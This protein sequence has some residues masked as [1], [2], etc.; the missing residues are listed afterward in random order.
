MAIQYGFSSCTDGYLFEVW[1][2][3]TNGVPVGITIGQVFYVVQADPIT[4]YS[5]CATCV[6]VVGFSDPVPIFTSGLTMVYYPTCNECLLD[7]DN[8][9]T[10]ETPTPTPTATQTPKPTLSS[11]AT[12]TPTRTLTPT[13]TRTLTPTPTITS[14]SRPI[15]DP[16]YIAT[17][18]A[19][20]VILFDPETFTFL[21]SPN[22]WFTSLGQNITKNNVKLWSINTANSLLEYNITVYPPTSTIVTLDPTIILLQICSSPTTNQLFIANG[23]GSKNEIQ[24]VSLTTGAILSTVGTLPSGYEFPYVNTYFGLYYDPVENVFYL[25]VVQTGQPYVDAIFVKY[26]PISQTFLAQSPPPG[27]DQI[28]NGLFVHNNTLYVTTYPTAMGGD[29]SI[30]SIV[31]NSGSFTFTQVLDIISELGSPTKTIFS[32]WINTRCTERSF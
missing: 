1:S 28:I 10:I 20:N 4:P 3:G 6:N 24:T 32:Q 26:D 7:P 9:I 16:C 2:T 27:P 29:S 25:N 5:G 15:I 22:P 31:E 18:N 12:P 14:S 17:F 8:I 19:N 11:T 21:T 30:Y 23:F 13:P